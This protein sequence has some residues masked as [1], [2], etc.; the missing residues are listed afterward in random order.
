VNP[1]IGGPGGGVAVDALVL[2]SVGRTG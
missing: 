1:V 2:L